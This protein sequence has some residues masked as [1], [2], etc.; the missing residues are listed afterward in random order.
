MLNTILLQS[1][2]SRWANIL[3]IVALIAVFYF[4][5][6]RPQQKRQN[7]IKKF[8]EGLKVG[9]A[10]VTAGGI[11]GKVKGI[12]DTTFTIEIAR[13]VRITVDKGSVYPSAQQAANDAAEKGK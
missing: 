1:M 10:V 12:D 5:M 8:R 4:M 6:I 7:E 9:D 13:D 2:N 11:Y 3:M